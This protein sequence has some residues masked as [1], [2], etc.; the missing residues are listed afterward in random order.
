MEYVIGD[1]QSRVVVF[2]FIAVFHI[3]YLNLV[4]C[5]LGDTKNEY[6]NLCM[7]KKW[8]KLPRINVYPR[9]RTSKSFFQKAQEQQSF[10]DHTSSIHWQLDASPSNALYYYPTIATDL[11]IQPVNLQLSFVSLGMASSGVNVH[12]PRALFTYQLSCLQ[13]MHRFSGTLLSL[14]V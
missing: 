9:P 13:V 12:I 1:E 2:H 10:H 14:P 3:L 5:L 11:S 4:E 8:S 7:H 6:Q